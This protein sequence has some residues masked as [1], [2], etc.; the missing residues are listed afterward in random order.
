MAG[1]VPAP[2]DMPPLFLRGG[3]VVGLVV[4]QA[5]FEVIEA[6]EY[7]AP[8]V[9][10]VQVGSLLGATLGF[11]SKSHGAQTQTRMPRAAR[12]SRASALSDSRVLSVT[13]CASR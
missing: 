9:L 13:P 8:V 4:A 11:V 6:S 2:S 5:G 10:V 7:G 12:Y 1:R 3:K